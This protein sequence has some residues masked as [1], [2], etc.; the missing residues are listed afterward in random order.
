MFDII[1]RIR[2]KRFEIIPVNTINK[3]IIGRGRISLFEIFFNECRY[4]KP[5]I[6]PIRSKNIEIKPNWITKQNAVISIPIS[7]MSKVMRLIIKIAIPKIMK[8]LGALFFPVFFSIFL[9]SA[10]FIIMPLFRISLL[11][12]KR[13]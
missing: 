7:V 5:P 13:L 9:Y 2:R 4:I 3:Y 1:I 12:I 11:I 10:G 6:S 8:D